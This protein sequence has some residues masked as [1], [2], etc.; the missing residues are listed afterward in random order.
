MKKIVCI[1]LAMLSLCII[2]SACTTGTQD[3]PTE[4]PE[5]TQQAA[6]EDETEAP[7]DAPTAE[8]TEAPTEEP[9]EEGTPKPALENVVLNKT[10]T[11][12]YNEG[13]E[14]SDPQRIV[15]D[16]ETTRWSGFDLGRDDP[17]GNLEHIIVIDLA[18]EYIL[19]D[20]LISFESL[21]GYYTIDVSDTGA[22]DSWRSVY[23]YD[24]YTEAHQAVDDDGTFEEG[25]KASF[26]RIY[27]NYP[28]NEVFDE[29]GDWPY[30]SIYEFCVMGYAA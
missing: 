26:I 9:T 29:S 27:I 18:G 23:I 7:T 19:N 6:V 3:D 21:T 22:D 5:T 10:V 30:C 25:T 24:D 4:A 8:P 13:G 28:E 16:D 14:L 2:M 15:D 20:F 11:T 12:D 17:K 1:I